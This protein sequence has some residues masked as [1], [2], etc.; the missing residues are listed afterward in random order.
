MGQ[1]YD[2]RN[3]FLFFTD[4]GDSALQKAVRKG[5]CKELEHFG[6]KVEDVADPQDM[7]TFLRSKLNWDLAGGNKR[8]LAWYKAL[9]ELR[10]KYIV[11]GER[12]CRVE[13]I[14]G[15]IHMQVP[16][17]QPKLRLFAR[18]EGS[19]SLPEAGAGWERALREDEDGYAV[20]AFVMAS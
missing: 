15:V 10:A 5:R 19:A 3:P 6:F 1:E 20:S 12:T 4:Y 7:F 2:E 13:L 14:E 17:K 9:L 8:M 18:I 16:M 11:D